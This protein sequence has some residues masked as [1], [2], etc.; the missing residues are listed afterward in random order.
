MTVRKYSNSIQPLAP[1]DITL[2]RPLLEAISRFR[3]CQVPPERIEADLAIGY[4]VRTAEAHY[5]MVS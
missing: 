5:R 4:T 2:D 3:G 1:V